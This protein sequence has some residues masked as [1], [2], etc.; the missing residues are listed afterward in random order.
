LDDQQE[1]PL[2]LDWAAGLIVGE[3]CFGFTL[4]RKKHNVVR[5]TPVFSIGMKDQEA[6]DTLDRILKEHDLP[7]YRTGYGEMHT[8]QVSGLKRLKRYT[9][10]L[11]P[12]LVGQKKEACRIVGLFVGRRLARPYNS[13]YSDEE[14]ELVKASRLNNAGK[15][16]RGKL[17]P[18]LL[19]ENPV[20]AEH[21]TAKT[22]CP[23]GHEYSPD[24][25]AFSNT[26]ARRCI[27]CDRASKQRHYE[28]RRE[29]SET[30]RSTPSLNEG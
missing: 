2:S 24:N 30:L 5:V 12:A 15:G 14:I 4:Q 27:I 19:R 10:V 18:D 23:Q 13:P 3:G 21:Q 9:D 26:G 22:H 25:V 8:I 1:R 29:S 7:V 6:I 17:S 28:R 11:H 20:F 16:S